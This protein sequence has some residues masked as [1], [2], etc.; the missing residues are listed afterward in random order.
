[1]VDGDERRDLR[2]KGE[3]AQGAEAGG[4]EA[5]AEVEDAQRTVG[6]RRGRA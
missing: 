3:R 2:V 6:Q 1:V 5:R 4:A